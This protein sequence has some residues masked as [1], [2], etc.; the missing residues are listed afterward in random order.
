MKTEL[1]G[2]KIEFLGGEK[3][4]WGVEREIFQFPVLAKIG[5]SCQ[6]WALSFLFDSKLGIK[7]YSHVE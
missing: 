6:S 5:P 3:E 2:G 4:T 1:L 7:L